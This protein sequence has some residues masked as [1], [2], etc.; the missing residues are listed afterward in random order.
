MKISVA[1]AT[2]N[3]EKYI[4]SQ[5]QSILDQDMPVDEVIICDDR[6]TDNTLIVAESFI[7]ENG[8]ENWKVYKNAQNL[9]F[10]RNFFN[11]ISKTTGDIIFL[12]D[13]DDIW[14]PNKV[15]VMYGI[16]LQNP[17]ILA[18]SSRYSLIDSFNK[19]I[20]NP[21]IINVDIKDDGAMEPVS[22]QSLIGCS[23]IR[24]CATCFRA[25]L[26]ASLIDINLDDLLA[27]DWL[28][29]ILAS[30]NGKNYIVNK[31][32]F[33]YRYHGEN[34]S[35]TAVSR[36]R[37]IGDIEKRKRGLEQSV[38]A[39]SYILEHSH[40]YKNMTQSIKKKLSKCIKFEKLRLKFLNTR[41]LLLYFLLALKV[42]NYKMY[43]KS[44]FKGIKVWAGDFLY[45]YNIGGAKGQK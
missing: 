15:S 20:E 28:I 9:G 2:Y 12:A 39:H 18:L 7:K 21:G 14:L 33:K 45:A 23:Y 41:N 8:L 1:I 17:K 16:M 40:E 24:G 36:T 35:L 4:K 26:K 44:F 13:Q 43:Y 30:L 5:L 42:G 27:H 34:A 10:S 3:G 22:V 31:I 6:S 11:A 32:L 25:S 29:N 19:D 37:L 38:F